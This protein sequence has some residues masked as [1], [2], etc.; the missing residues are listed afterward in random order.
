MAED[1]EKQTSEEN[2][3]DRSQHESTETSSEESTEEANVE[4]SSLEDQ[5]AQLSEELETQKDRA[6]RAQAEL[7]NVRKRLLREADQMRQYAVAPLASEL[8]PLMDNLQRAIA[9]GESSGRIEEL[10]QGLEMVSHQFEETLRKFGVEKIP[11]VDE[12][13]DPNKHEALQ[14]VPSPDHEPMQIV[15]EVETG[16]Q[17][18]DRVIRPSKVIVSSGPPA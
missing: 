12:Q 16:W 17:M 14:Q 5:I 18:H 2:A 4:P 9:A 13:F 8:L 1:T 7:E 15:Q 3:D 11:A 6:L 10:L